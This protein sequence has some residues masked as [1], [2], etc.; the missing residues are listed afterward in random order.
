MSRSVGIEAEQKAVRFLE[1]QGYRIVERNYSCRLGEID[2]IAE[3]VDVLCFVEVRSRKRSRYGYPQESIT[4]EKKR[5]ISL[6]ARHFLLARKIE[7]RSCRFDVVSIL[8][9]EAPVLQRN[10][11]ESNYYA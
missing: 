6:T 3:E 10:A 1:S 4:Y 9:D 8:G 2:I 11:F 7:G 5:R